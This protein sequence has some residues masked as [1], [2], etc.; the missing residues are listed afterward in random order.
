MP[1]G[2]AMRIGM[3]SAVSADCE[4]FPP[5]GT[6]SISASAR[7]GT[8]RPAVD[9]LGDAQADWRLLE[10]RREVAG[11]ALRV[12]GQPIL[13][14]PG[15]GQLLAA[16]GG[17]LGLGIGASPGVPQVRGEDDHAEAEAA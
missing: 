16:P 11:P 10:Q 2:P 7:L 14:L 5:G 8:I 1:S 6:P 9:V 17:R 13:R 4:M 3:R 12:A 15:L